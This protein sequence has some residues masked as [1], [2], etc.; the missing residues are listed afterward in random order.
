MS[1]QFPGH[2]VH[3]T[4]TGTGSDVVLND[5]KLFPLARTA[6]LERRLEGATLQ[7]SVFDDLDTDPSEAG[8]VGIAAVELR[9]LATGH[10]TDGVFTVFNRRARAL[11][12]PSTLT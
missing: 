4:S 12:R 8:L 2:H 5:V 10:P 1:Y 6:A 11:A 3:D 9:P 7:L